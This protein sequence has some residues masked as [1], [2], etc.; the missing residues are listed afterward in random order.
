M[1]VK[2]SD[3]MVK[4]EED[5][6]SGLTA[7]L[8]ARLK[9][10]PGQVKSFRVY[11]KSLDARRKSQFYFN[12][13]LVAELER[14]PAGFPAWRERNTFLPQPG[15]KL[16]ERP[17]IVGFGPAGIFAALTLVELG[18]RPVIF[19]RGRRLEERHRDIEAFYR[20]QVLDPDSNVQ[21]GEGGAG[22]WSDGKL[23]SRSKDH[24][25]VDKFLGTLVRFGAPE[26]ILY[27]HKPHLGTDGIRRLVKKVREFLLDQGADIHFESKMTGLLTGNGYVAGIEINGREKY[28]SPYL[29]L[30]AGHSARD[31]MALLRDAGL[32]LEP[33]PFALG[34][35]LEHPRPLIDL[36]QYGSKYA[37]RSELGAADY[38]LTHND[39]KTGRG[40]FSFCCCPGG[41]I[42]AAASEPGGSVV[43]GMSPAA[44]SG[45][46]TNAAVVVS[47]SP[48]DFTS[49]DPLSGIEF[50]RLVEQAAFRAAG[51]SYLGP[52]QRLPDFLADRPSSSL[53]ANS[54]RIGTVPAE[55][56]DFLPGFVVAE[57]RSAF[58]S[59]AG[60]FPGFI[61]LE[62]LLIG[63]E[64][65]TSSPVRIRR[66]PGGETEG[67]RGLYPIGEGS[68]YAGGI[69]SSAVDAM[70][71]VCSLCGIRLP[72]SE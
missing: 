43:N 35:R 58:R 27:H 26:E 48:A 45:A 37:G 19:E 11:R 36:M 38:A 53:P 39:P 21:F 10:S 52:A 66:G 22:A 33:K 65:R 30:A 50:Q 12:Y 25:F 54:L 71:A 14:Q 61:G 13:T 3:I 40:T 8:A 20:E 15:R 28:H 72:E 69:T 17:L 62:A 9:L 41:E 34:A 51:E 70:K 68:G 59:W 42:L 57:L 64:T 18:V 44:R 2:V 31:T 49:S 29:L 55:L 6:E 24:F 63:A 4:V 56:K 23:L 47:V 1:K 7:A 16:E 60:R 5:D 67:L 32:P 46:F